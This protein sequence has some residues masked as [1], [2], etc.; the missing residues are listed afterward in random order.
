MLTPEEE[1]ELAGLET[2]VG[3]GLSKDEEE[4]LKALEA[5]VGGD[6]EKENTSLVTDAGNV[7]DT[8]QEGV[9]KAVDTAS[10][11]ARGA[12][13]FLNQL[14]SAASTSLI[15]PA[16]DKAGKTIYGDDFGDEYKDLS[17]AA[18]Y[19]QNLAMYQSDEQR[20]RENTGWAGTAA[21]LGGMA[22]GMGKLS[23]AFKIAGRTRKAALYNRAGGFHAKVLN[24]AEKIYSTTKKGKIALGAAN[25]F[26]DTSFMVIREFDRYGI[27]ED[28]LS[29]GA[30]AL[31]VSS[32]V[33][34][35]GGPVLR[36]LGGGAKMLG[37]NLR[38][39][40]DYLLKSSVQNSLRVTKESVDG[41][42]KKHGKEVMETLAEKVGI[43]NP[44]LADNPELI[45]ENFSS[46]KTQQ[47][48]SLKKWWDTYGDEIAPKGSLDPKEL[49]QALDNALRPPHIA[50]EVKKGVD[51]AVDFAR[52]LI[53][54]LEKDA[55]NITSLKDV[56]TVFKGLE[57]GSIPIPSKVSKEKVRTISRVLQNGLDNVYSS[58]GTK[59][60]K[61][62]E[63]V[64]KEA[65]KDLG[66][67]K[68]GKRLA[69]QDLKDFDDFIARKDSEIISKAEQAG[70]IDDTTEV[71]GIEDLADFGQSA[72]KKEINTLD[73]AA[74]GIQKEIEDIE[75]QLK[76]GSSKLQSVKPKERDLKKA[77]AEVDK[78]NKKIETVER[79]PISKSGSGIQL[80]K[81][82]KA[83]EKQ[84]KTIE[85]K[86][87]EAKI[88]KPDPEKVRALNATIK[89]ETAK[90]GYTAKAMSKAKS[91][92]A[93]KAVADKIAKAKETL[94]KTKAELESLKSS[95]KSG[96][97]KELLAE[98]NLV[99]KRLSDSTREFENLQSAGKKKRDSLSGLKKEQV[100]KQRALE[101][102]EADLKEVKEAAEKVDLDALKTK[103][104]ELNDSL[105]TNRKEVE[106]IQKDAAR[107]IKE[108][109]QATRQLLENRIKEHDDEISDLNRRLGIE[110]GTDFSNLNL[111]G[112]PDD[113]IIAASNPASLSKEYEL[114]KDFE[115]T[116]MAT[117]GGPR[118]DGGVLVST[119][120]KMF[121]GAG[122]V[123]GVAGGAAIG[124]TTGA[125]VA[126]AVGTKKVIQMLAAASKQTESEFMRKGITKI[127]D[128]FESTLPYMGDPTTRA[129]K[130]ELAN[131]LQENKKFATDEQW[132]QINSTVSKIKLY[133]NPLPRNSQYAF[134]QF[135]DVLNLVNI[136]HPLYAQNLV[137]AQKQGDL[138]ALGITL[139]QMSKDP[140]L[141]RYFE[142]G[143]GFDGWLPSEE[144][145]I[146]HAEQMLGNRQDI[147][148]VD[149]K[150]IM[151]KI[152]QEGI[153][154]TRE[155][156]DKSARIVLTAGARDRYKL[157]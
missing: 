39:F 138:N 33:E 114:L 7:V 101:I 6:L 31:G 99:K 144:D 85:N 81:R 155:E 127:A 111:K 130:M 68:Y 64:I 20:A 154:F 98:K 143:V 83:D 37:G 3:E 50:G 60:Y 148:T 125:V 17:P 156:I 57:E 80:Q 92:E 93:K 88:S 11:F 87:K 12:V 107:K 94:A 103:Q 157:R 97:L 45:K 26:S 62:S 91:P 73:D 70:F 104:K 66:K 9:G 76:L 95:D 1:K 29:Q 102:A 36:L 112:P 153:I 124:G 84:L 16:L 43:K 18:K 40:D 74:K 129:L 56:F 78:L 8:V 54:G 55:Y 63:A 32:A 49:V 75:D 77:R 23:K 108:E 44:E 133:I 42:Y 113:A 128:A 146:Q 145:R 71:L 136:E 59:I 96:N 82:V 15:E 152:M 41:F 35:L 147:P 89:K 51:P 69:E 121:K 65:Q 150:F 118:T 67:L 13:P 34:T 27:R 5:E 134:D 106:S 90:I 135:E 47:L 120:Q 79:T 58:T 119:L 142:A 126:T 109:E 139:D 140:V 21:E 30:W 24:R 117:R 61:K 72:S 137:M 25:V 105:K 132:A 110:D 122:G 116:F 131:H 22:L 2:E 86:I 151:A 141:K 46:L 10:M 38:A 48:D 100:A 115:S 52:S 4:E 28:A 14:A 19:Q 53:G 149:R 123:L